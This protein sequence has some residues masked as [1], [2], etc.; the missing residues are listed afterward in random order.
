MNR[1][2]SNNKK[3][4]KKNYFTVTRNVTAVQTVKIMRNNDVFPL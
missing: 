1:I 2:N 4:F 3:N